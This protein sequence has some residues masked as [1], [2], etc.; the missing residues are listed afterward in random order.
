MDS[1]KYVWMILKK[2]KKH[3]KVYNPSWPE[4]NHLAIQT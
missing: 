4:T 3:L 2:K 1:Y